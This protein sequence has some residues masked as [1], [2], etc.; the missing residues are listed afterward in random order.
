MK[1]ILLILPF[2][3]ITLFS[4]AQHTVSGI[5]QDKSDVSLLL[6]GVSVYIPEL[7]KSDISKEG[8]TYIL[9]NVGIGTVHIQFSK[10][11][12][13]TEIK[14]ISTKDSAVVIN[15]EMGKSIL[16][17]QEISNTSF[18]SQLST[19]TNFPVVE[20]STK[21]LSKSASI[22]FLSALTFKPGLETMSDGISNNHLIVRG[23]GSNRIAYYSDGTRIENQSW[24]DKYSLGLNF[25]G[26]ENLEV[27]SGPAALIYGANAAG[28]ALILRE[29]KAEITGNKLGDVKMGYNSN[30]LGLGIEAGFKGTSSKGIFY[31]LR[32]GGQSHTSYIQ[33]SG[34][35]V[36]LNSEERPFASNSK[37]NSANVKVIL[38]INKKWGMSKIL[39][40]H[41]NQKNG[42]IHIPEE[43]QNLLDGI[44]RDREI[45]TPY[46]NVASD[47]ASSETT[48]LK[49]KSKINLNLSY[50]TNE[51][52]EY[53]N[54]FENVFENSEILKLQ[55]LNFDLKYSS[56]AA[57]KVGFTIGTQGGSSKFDNKGLVSRSPNA[58]EMDLAGYAF[59]RYNI[60][61]WNFLLG[62]R[63]DSKSDELSSYTGKNDTS[64]SRPTINEKN[65]ISIA[66]GSVGLSFQPI[67]NLFLKTNASTGFTTPNYLQLASFSEHSRLN[68]FEI[69]NLEL[70]IEKNIQVDLGAQIELPGFSVEV[71]GFSNMITDYIYSY[72][73]GSDTIVPIDS[74]SVDTIS[75]YSF[76]QADAT[77]NGAEISVTIN[78]PAVHW[79][80]LELA[81][82]FLD[83]KFKNGGYLPMLPS[84]KLT[85]AI[86]FSG[87]K[88]NYVYKPYLNF[89][90]RN[91]FDQKNLAVSEKGRDGY[92]LLDFHLGG[93]FSWGKQYFG[94]DFSV[95]NIFNTNY[96]S[97][98]SLLRGIGATGIY[99]MGRNVAIQVHVPFGLNK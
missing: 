68:R 64:G 65:T 87:E 25:N 53:K 35:E 9:T 63:Y 29:E 60:R 70:N 61:K 8:G 46:Q 72:N 41:F 83:G 7:N 4:N 18:N 51:N 36:K 21:E 67:K 10:E 43:A 20:F 99:D 19:T 34:K 1:K 30:T 57:K 49:G 44:E 84:N 85:A 45:P 38:G 76:A 92:L 69:G 81:Y 59:V 66:N 71:R 62:G 11:G 23:S 80:K 2:I 90:V 48:V 82:S 97:Q 77:I 5:A 88:L 13:Q 27:V 40:S 42:I 75:V 56:D 39:F 86:T 50:Q 95:N 32:L 47:L 24:D 17:P 12:Y 16:E 3:I 15:I 14:C 89:T 31:S 73:T 79:L 54:N 55:T 58:K 96:F 37:F 98:L 78:P 52:K 74:N 6:E 94:I 26:V 93:K 91:Y 33:G 28:G 22:D